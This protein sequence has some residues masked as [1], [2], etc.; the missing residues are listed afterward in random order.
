VIPDEI[1]ASPTAGGLHRGLSEA[2]HDLIATVP[3]DRHSCPPTSLPACVRLSMQDSAELTVAKTATSPI[4]CSVSAEE[5]SAR[6]DGFL[7]CGGRKIDAW[8]SKLKVVEVLFDDNPDAFSNINTQ[9]ELRAFERAAEARI[10]V[11]LPLPGAPGTW[12]QLFR[13]PA[14]LDAGGRLRGLPGPFRA[15]PARKARAPRAVG[16]PNP[17]LSM[18]GDQ[19]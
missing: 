7:A 8:Y 10:P 16:L 12:L 2:Q 18:R 3:C 1:A 13:G 11:A 9:D 4:P 17:K 14:R 5:R 6:T 19:F 15:G